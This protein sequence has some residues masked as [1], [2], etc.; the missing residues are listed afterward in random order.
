MIMALE[1][2]LIHIHQ[3]YSIQQESVFGLNS[4]NLP[5]IFN[6]KSPDTMK[7]NEL[8]TQKLIS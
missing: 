5:R 7:L 6:E 1:Y 2:E 3:E 4:I 8:Y